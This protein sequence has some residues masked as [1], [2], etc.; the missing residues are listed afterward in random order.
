MNFEFFNSCWWFQI[1]QCEYVDRHLEKMKQKIKNWLIELSLFNLQMIFQWMQ[2]FNRILHLKEIHLAYFFVTLTKFGNHFH[3]WTNL[4]FFL[5]F[6]YFYEK[7]F[8]D[9][10]SDNWRSPICLKCKLK[11]QVCFFIFKKKFK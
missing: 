3:K 10:W 6:K 8:P 7:F 9:E 11:S 1:C 5:I 4:F 2:Y